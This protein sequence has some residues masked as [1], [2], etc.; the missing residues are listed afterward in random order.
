MNRI[1]NSDENKVKISTLAMNYYHDTC[2]VVEIIAPYYT[3]IAYSMLN[4]RFD[5]HNEYLT[6]LNSDLL[7][8]KLK[9]CSIIK[10]GTVGLDNTF[11]N[12]KSIISIDEKLLALD[13]KLTEQ[14]KDDGNLYFEGIARNFNLIEEGLN[15]LCTINQTRKDNDYIEIYDWMREEYYNSVQ[16]EDIKGGY[17]NYLM[18]FLYKDRITQTQIEREI[19]QYR[20][21]LMEDK[22]LGSL[23]MAHH[24]NKSEL[25][26]RIILMD[27]NT[28]DSIHYLF[29]TLG[30]I[31]LL[32]AWKNELIFERLPYKIAKEKKEMVQGVVFVGSW[33]EER[34]KRAW[35][36][37]FEYMKNEKKA[38]YDWCCLHH[39]LTFYQI[40]EKT[41]FKYF[42][43]WLNQLSGITLIN[44][45][46]IRKVSSYYFVE[47]VET[48]WSVQQMQEH[49]NNGGKEKMTSQWES[50]F[51]RYSL[52]CDKIRE[53]L[54]EQI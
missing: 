51:K 36:K 21:N 48:Q 49:I 3:Y 17:V 42:M 19:A 9:I 31:E 30:K 50:K 26:K 28:I 6:Q 41:T 7:E 45:T 10:A 14:L 22:E 52:I 53:I 37:I 38:D 2:L 29:D 5:K 46:N 11:T 25:C 23:W 24:E 33:N 8:L 47:K 54:L 13:K 32:E 34:F 35:P 27:L 16:W 1:G 12:E 43:E 39:T 15:K 20:R 4:I 18:E 44:D 40:I